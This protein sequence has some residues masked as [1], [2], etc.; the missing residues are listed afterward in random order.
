MDKLKTLM[1]TNSVYTYLN[2]LES[3]ALRISD[4]SQAEFLHAFVWEL[5]DCVKA[6]LHLKSPSTYAKAP[7]MALDIDECLHLLYH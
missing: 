1:Q 5:K 2:A 6:E 7:C 4:A 3:L